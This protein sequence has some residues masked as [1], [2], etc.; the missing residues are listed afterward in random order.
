MCLT[1]SLHVDLMFNNSFYIPKNN[2]SY[3]KSTHFYYNCK[4]H[5]PNAC[6]IIHFGVSSDKY[7]WVEKDTIPEGP[8]THWVSKIF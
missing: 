2:V 3:N 7:I 5:N 6:Y 1:I 8:I 4:V